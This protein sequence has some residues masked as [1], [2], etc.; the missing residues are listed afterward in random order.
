[1][2]TVGSA[3]VTV[4]RTTN[5][6]RLALELNRACILHPVAV[7]LPLTIE[8]VV[9]ILKCIELGTTTTRPIVQ[10]SLVLS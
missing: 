10:H 2:L 3:T 4:I 8:I 9:G 6:V 1:M 7:H 5:Q